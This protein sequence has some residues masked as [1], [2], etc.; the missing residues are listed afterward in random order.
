MVRRILTGAG[1]S[2]A[3]NLA[4]SRTGDLEAFAYP[5]DHEGRQT[6]SVKNPSERRTRIAAD[7]PGAGSCSARCDTT[8]AA[9]SPTSALFEIGRVFHNRHWTEDSRVPDQPERVA[10]AAV[11]R[12]GPQG[13]GS[14]ARIA[15][16]HV[17]TSIWKLIGEGM[18]LDYELKAA[19]HPGFHPGRTADV[20]VDGVRIGHVGEIH[21]VTAAAYDLEG[22]VG[23]R[24]NGPGP[25]HRPGT[26][27]AADRTKPLST[28][29]VRSRLRGRRGDARR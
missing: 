7:F 1:F 26:R 3:V 8:S 25:D 27:L 6:I 4:L 19:S 17:A 2:Q 14:S 5:V 11:G 20:F 18:G 16:G 15:D 24:R 13:L 12:F 29:G 10:F 9:T 22:R 23:G 21:P 28:C